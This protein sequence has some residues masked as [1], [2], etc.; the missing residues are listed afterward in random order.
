MGAHS[1]LG[2]GSCEGIQ[3]ERPCG[4]GGGGWWSSLDIGK[5]FWPWGRDPFLFQDPGFTGSGP[6]GVAVACDKV[7]GTSLRSL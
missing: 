5:G 4:L 2:S 1:Q 6:Q 3:L 7:W